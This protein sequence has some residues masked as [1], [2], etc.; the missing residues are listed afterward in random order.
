LS[1]SGRRGAGPVG[2]LLPRSRRQRRPIP[3]SFFAKIDTEANE[4]LASALNIRS[5]PTLMVFRDQIILYS[6]AG[7]LP[8]S[9]LN[10][11]IAQARALNMDDVRSEIAQ[12]V[13]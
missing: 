3:I 10:D 1:I 8:V 6:E 4:Q 7:A 12:Q 11:V 5:I 13:V 2:H 9:A